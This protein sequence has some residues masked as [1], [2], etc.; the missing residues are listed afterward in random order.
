MHNFWSCQHSVQIWNQLRSEHGVTVAAPPS[1]TCS[2]SKLSN[3]LLGWFAKAHADERE[4]MIQ[5]VY[6]LWLARNET[7][8]GKRIDEPHE[9]VERVC[10][11]MREWQELGS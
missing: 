7:K 6:A 3:W 2:Q 5:A 9:I 4:A 8:N 1:F 11:F 10:S